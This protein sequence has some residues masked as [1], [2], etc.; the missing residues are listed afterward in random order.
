[1]RKQD[2]SS[3]FP[4]MEEIKKSLP[5]HPRLIIPPNPNIEKTDYLFEKRKKRTQ[6]GDGD[7]DRESR[8]IS[9]HPSRFHFQKKRREDHAPLKKKSGTWNI[10]HFFYKQTC[11]FFF[12]NFGEIRSRRISAGLLCAKS[13]FSPQDK[14]VK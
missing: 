8:N 5:R 7:M 10:S 14:V 9:K 13:R 6:M 1:M 4:R 3:S 11:F 12:R 2:Y